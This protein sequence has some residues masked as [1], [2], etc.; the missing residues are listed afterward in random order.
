MKRVRYE[1]P[2]IE[3]LEL[4]VE[5]GFALSDMES[6]SFENPILKDEDQPW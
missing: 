2:E 5:Q 3:V 4:A 1:V 6:Q